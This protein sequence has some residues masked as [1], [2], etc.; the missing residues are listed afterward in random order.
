M[1]R[2]ARGLPDLE[3]D[4]DA[5]VFAD[6]P[7]HAV[8]EDAHEGL[9]EVIDVGAAGSRVFYAGPSPRADRTQG[10]QVEAPPS[11]P[12]D[13]GLDPPRRVACHHR[14]PAIP[15]PQ[16]PDRDEGRPQRD[17]HHDMH[18][19]Q[20]PIATAA[21]PFRSRSSMT[22]SRTGRA[23]GTGLATTA[24][25]PAGTERRRP[26]AGP[27]FAGNRARGSRS[28]R[29]DRDAASYEALAASRSSADGSCQALGGVIRAAISGVGSGV[30]KWSSATILPSA[31]R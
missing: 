14:T 22:P 25:R 30:W 2:S 17:D 28:A 21:F 4:L 7:L 18:G 6:P 29:R 19:K 27:G 23:H 24:S 31:R 10:E 1:V 8:P 9:F 20:R 5:S 15:A 12:G 26:P 3:P 16:A 13:D 11:R